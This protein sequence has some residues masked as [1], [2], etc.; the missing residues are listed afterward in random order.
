MIDLVRGAQKRFKLG[1]GSPARA[2]SG[3]SQRSPG[4]ARTVLCSSRC[5]SSIVIPV[6][7]FFSLK[8]EPSAY[9]G[10]PSTKQPFCRTP[11]A[12]WA[13]RSGFYERSGFTP[14]G[15]AEALA[16]AT[17]AS[18]RLS[19]G[20]SG[21]F[22]ETTKMQGRT[23]LPKTVTAPKISA[24]AGDAAAEEQPVSRHLEGTTRVLPGL[25]V[26]AGL[27][28]ADAGPHSGRAE[29]GMA[30]HRRIW[31]FLVYGALAAIASAR[32]KRNRANA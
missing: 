20:S 18:P 30:E 10:S 11:E 4:S 24:C 17:S 32:R 6:V 22:P 27:L 9:V 31:P 26:P 2:R 5:C 19:G 14:V 7:S 12:A 13:R 3:S 21:Q 8:V 15:C 1:R 23:E 28:R 29:Q 25:F 16:P